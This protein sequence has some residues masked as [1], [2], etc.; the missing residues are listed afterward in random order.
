MS[1]SDT[2]FDWRTETTL[3]GTVSRIG[4]WVRG[5]CSKCGQEDALLYDD[6]D[7]PTLLCNDCSHA[8]IRARGQRNE[9]CDAPDCD[10]PFAW[11]DPL[12]GK[13]EFFCAQHHAEH[14]TVFQNRWANSAREG[15]VLGLREKVKCALAG[16]GTDCKGEIKYRSAEKMSICNKHAGKTSSGPEWH[17]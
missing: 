4:Q 3:K 15:R 11:R 10:A 5:T 12:S 6:Y 16:R 17:Q 8:R 14:G 13:N 7:D 2:D 9:Q 1:E